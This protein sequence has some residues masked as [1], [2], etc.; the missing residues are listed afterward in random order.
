MCSVIKGAYYITIAIASVGANFD[1]HIWVL[2]NVAKILQN[3]VQQS[4]AIFCL[5]IILPLYGFNYYQLA[6]V[7]NMASYVISSKLSLHPTP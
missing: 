2:A 4:M 5:R 7:F 6:P 1:F 3:P